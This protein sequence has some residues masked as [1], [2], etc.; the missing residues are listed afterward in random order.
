MKVK[1]KGKDGFCLECNETTK[2]LS[3]CS[4]QCMPV[5]KN[6]YSDSIREHFNTGLKLT[7]G[8]KF[9]K[10]I[11]DGSGKTPYS[12]R[13]DINSR[14]QIEVRK[15]DFSIRMNELDGRL[16]G[17]HTIKFDKNTSKSYNHIYM[18][19]KKYDEALETIHALMRMI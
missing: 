12:K 16:G 1:C 11:G 8:W 7:N 9:G 6:D 19:Y 14:S 4:C 10:Y 5:K 3:I 13:D 15:R 2:C 17:G 18:K